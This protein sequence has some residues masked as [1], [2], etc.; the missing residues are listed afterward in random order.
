M[1]YLD[2]RKSQR[3]YTNNF[4]TYCLLDE[5]DK[6]CSEGFGKTK[7]ISDL[8]LQMVTDKIIESDYILVVATDE[9]DN[10]IEMKGRVCHRTMDETGVIQPRKFPPMRPKTGH[11]RKR[12]ARH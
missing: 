7:N 8:G 3:A 9:R 5:N 1:G 10:I 4:I 11:G 6:I 2:K 12:T